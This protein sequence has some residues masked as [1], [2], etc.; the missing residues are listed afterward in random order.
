MDNPPRSRLHALLCLSLVL[1]VAAPAF[2]QQPAAT[3]QPP[4]SLRFAVIGDSGTGDKPQIDV[5]NQ[6][7]QAYQRS[8]FSLVLMLGDNL[9]A[10]NWKQIEPA[11]AKPYKPLLDAGVRFYATIGNH[12]E[13]T[14]A[15]QLA[16]PAF[17]MGG[18]RNY[19]FAP[20]GAL[21]EFFTIDSLL[22]LTDSSQLDWLDKALAASTAHWKVVF[23][24]NPPYSPGSRH[25]DNAKLEKTL[26]PMLERHHVQIVLSGHEHFFAQLAPVNGVNYIISGSGGKIQKGGLQPDS[27]TVYGNDQAHQF[28]LVTLTPGAFTFQ[29]IGETG[30]VL[31]TASIPYV[32][33]AVA[34]AGR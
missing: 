15:Q 11:F 8:P 24:H 22:A 18:R 27:R 20:A 2:A 30:E 25:G 9:Y 13:P 26:V 21:V 5:A 34:A 14:A 28:V 19:S 29:V 33:S 4:D 12:D 23:I 31:H 1:L 32:A 6:M 10:S 3:P 7:W 16:Y 17:N